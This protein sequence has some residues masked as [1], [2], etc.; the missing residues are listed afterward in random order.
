MLWARSALLKVQTPLR[1]P[2]CL[3]NTGRVPD[4]LPRKHE[5]AA[6]PSLK[7]KGLAHLLGRQKCPGLET[8]EEEGTPLTQADVTL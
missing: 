4:T 6:T 3:W 5:G 7:A 1:R 2:T 8:L